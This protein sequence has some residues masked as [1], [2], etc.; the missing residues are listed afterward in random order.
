MPSVLLVDDKEENLYLLR[1]L[2]TGNGYEVY[3]ATNGKEAL[4]LAR[5]KPPDLIISDIL[6]P[7][8]DGFT[9]CRIC[10]QDPMLGEV[11][12]IF[13]TATYTDQKDE[14]LALSLG[15]D[16]FLLKP[17][18]PDR[19]ISMITGVLEEHR[20]GRIRAQPKSPEPEE[21]YLREYNAVL[22]RK[23][24]EK[25]AQ[26]EEANHRLAEKD[27][28]NQATLDATTARLAVIG[29][30]GEVLSAN[31]AWTR[32]ALRP[33]E[34][35]LLGLRVGDDVRA[36]LECHHPEHS[37]AMQRIREGLGAILEGRRAELELEIPYG[38][39][40]RQWLLVRIER[41]GAAGASAIIT[42]IDVTALKRAEQATADASRRKDRLLA[43]L[44]HE[45]RNPLA[46]IKSAS[47]ILRALYLP[48]PKARRAAEVIDRQAS[49]LAHIVDDLLD[50][51]RI[52]GGTLVVKSEPT[53]LAQVV[54][55]IASDYGSGFESRGITLRVD[56]S[57]EPVW[58]LGDATRLA[59]IVGNL[60][61]NARR[62]TDRG[63]RVE[64]RLTTDPAQRTTSLVVRDTGVGMTAELLARLF[65]PFEQAQ[66]SSARTRGGFGLGLT[67]VKGL[68]ELHGGEVHATSAGPGCGT[69]LSVRLPLTEPPRREAQPPRAPLIGG[70]RVLIIEDN[71]DAAEMLQGFLELAGCVVQTAYDGRSGLALAQA[72]P[73]EAILCDIGLPDI[74]G[75]AV[76]RAVRADP[77]LRS[78][79][80]IALTGYGPGEVRRQAQEAG[81]DSYITKPGDP[82]QL[83][84]LVALSHEQHAPVS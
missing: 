62:F 69:E 61:D 14:Q 64:V 8:M 71:R 84:R 21:Q 46:P 27:I 31:K 40:Q 50:V 83:L 70:V 45:L 52:R 56:V 13:Y 65:E 68:V 18:E 12:F 19:F 4:E 16:R 7:V 36:R 25:L 11:P 59:Q 55:S 1:A 29:Q 41:V 33:G 35:E 15:A 17:L 5:G 73:P 63:G 22:I 34:P 9:L 39:G 20:R 77:R 28:F 42:C 60:L 32:Q 57:A 6:M 2:L 53:D 24:E 58:V 48:D 75:Y 23:L 54:R 78:V 51:E 76:A 80:L 26:L 49:H 38:D 43:L 81:F 74:D 67:L 3:S 66:Q 79:R 47:Q 72:H 44:A 37:Q 82:E 10:K 30:R